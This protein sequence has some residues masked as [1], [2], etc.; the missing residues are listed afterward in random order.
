MGATSVTEDDVKENIVDDMPKED[1]GV[2]AN[3]L[4]ALKAKSQAKQQDQKMKIVGKKERSLKFGVIGSGQGGSR[5][6][7][8]FYNLSYP[9]VC[10]NTAMQDLKFCNVPDSNKL[11]LEYTLGGASKDMDLGRAAAEANIDAI[12]EL[13]SEKLSD[14][15]VFIFCT[16]LGGGS[17]AGSAEPI[18]SM[19]NDLGK[20]V[21]VIAALPMSNEDAQTKLN[22]LETLSRLSKLAQTKQI[23]NLIVVDNAKI[24]TIYSNTSQMNFYSVANKAIVEPLDVF[25]TLSAMPSAVKSLDPME[26]TKI[27]LDSEGLTIYAEMAVEDYTNDVSVA[28]AVLNLNGNLLASGFDLKQSKYVGV[29]FS[30]PESVWAKIPASS[31]NYAMAMV[32][33]QCG[34]PQGVFKGLYTVDSNEDVVKVY[35]IFSGLGLPAQRVEQ[36]KEETKELT[37][38]AK[39]KNEAR[40]LNLNLDTGKGTVTEAEKVRQKIAAKSSTFGKFVGNNITDRRK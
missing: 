39:V 6:A 8:T 23:A 32:N 40:N 2:D 38:V 4:A 11:L 19:L 10:V 15:Q 30:A 35:S 21:I 12:R 13:V 22:S 34:S 26:L 9:A 24:E 28:E 33:D 36:L 18:I 16:S 7:E 29:I 31:T 17:G 27:L 5:L 20:P 1:S 25:N 37:N 14:S 3:K